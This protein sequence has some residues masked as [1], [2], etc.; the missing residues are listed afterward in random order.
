MSLP[1]PMSFSNSKSRAA[2]ITLSPTGANVFCRGRCLRRWRCHR[3]KRL[4]VDITGAC[5]VANQGQDFFEADVCGAGVVISEADA[6]FL[7]EAKKHRAPVI[8]ARSQGFYRR[9]DPPCVVVVRPRSRYSFSKSGS[10][11]FP[12]SP[13]GAKGSSKN[14]P[15]PFASWRLNKELTPYGVKRVVNRALEIVISTR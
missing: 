9:R 15:I 14:A 7:I 8:T 4:E 13:L 6:F 12:L 11:E 3:L 2:K 10:A 5:R 1:K